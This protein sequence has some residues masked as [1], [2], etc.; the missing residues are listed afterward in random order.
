MGPGAV[1][2]GL[3]KRLAPGCQYLTGGTAAEVDALLQL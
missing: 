2:T 3:V 1:L